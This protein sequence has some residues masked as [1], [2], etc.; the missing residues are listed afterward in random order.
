MRYHKREMRNKKVKKGCEVRYD[1]KRE[2]IEK[3]GDARHDKREMRKKGKKKDARC[4]M[5]KE[6]RKKGKKGGEVRYDKKR[7]KKMEKR[8]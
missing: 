8:R 4:G 6:K 5:I 7:N 2:N 1:K 3:R